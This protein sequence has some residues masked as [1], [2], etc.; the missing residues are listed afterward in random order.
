MRTA[1]L[2]SDIKLNA[3]WIKGLKADYIKWKELVNINSHN[4][5]YDLIIAD[6]YAD[7]SIY[8][9]ELLR[10]KNI[11]PDL[12]LVLI[13][14]ESFAITN[15]W[16]RALTE[17]D[18]IFGNSYNLSK[19]IELQS[20]FKVTEFFVPEDIN[21]EDKYIE[22]VKSDKLLIVSQKPYSLW[23]FIREVGVLAG[24]FALTKYKL[25][26][27][28]CQDL[29]KV[30]KEIE[31]SKIVYLS[32]PLDDEG[33][34]VQYCC[35]AK[36]ILVSIIDYN[37]A[38][39]CYPYT[40]FHKGHKRQGLLL[41]WIFTSKAFS[42]FFIDTAKHSS[43]NLDNEN[44]VYNFWEKLRYRIT[45]PEFES[46]QS[47]MS[48]IH[49]Y[50]GDSNIQWGED[51]CGLVCLL[52]NGSEYIETFLM[53][54]RQM[55]IAHF[56]FIDNGSDDDTLDLLRGEK[57]VTIYQTSLLHKFYEN[58]IRRLVIEKHSK[59]RWC[60]NVDIDEL[61]DYPDSDKISLKDLLGYLSGNRYTSMAGYMLDMFTKEVIFS[62]REK[63]NLKESYRFYDISNIEKKD[64]YAP[65][66]IA[67]CN[68]NKLS[69]NDIK[70]Y[71]GGIRKTLFSS[72]VAGHYLLTK[73][74]LIY[75]DGELEPV[76]NPHYCNK[77]KVADVSSVLYHYKFTPSFKEK[78]LESRKTNR[79]IKFA[80]RQYDQYYKKIGDDKSL[81]IDTPGSKELFS[82]NDLVLNGFIQV[83][84]AYKKYVESVCLQQQLIP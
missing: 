38:K 79:Y 81:I 61:F 70:C 41:L 21:L 57:D 10:I 40:I 36:T 83:S 14:K 25:R 17:A 68:Y 44:R 34:L 9:Q 37:P 11:Y 30:Y 13:I 8:I 28:N 32:D 72:N 4:L 76:T 53:H 66:V 2:T 31:S 82:V 12:L 54:Y 65:D 71:F 45:I 24:L 80:Q 73:H 77:S 64:Y 52:R 42:N 15:L 1:Y 29:T 27:I 51:E 47:L 33:M 67:Y 46:N 23:D 5:T 50:F 26:I 62:N 39:V 75:L 7:C 69:S 60:L 18:Y 58:D 55:G 74:P 48:Y 6:I 56:I 16:M 63:I 43:V 35:N 19:R 49:H 78:V 59:N 3:A 84:P 20:G 22:S